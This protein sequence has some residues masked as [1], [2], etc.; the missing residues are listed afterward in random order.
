ML[1]FKVPGRAE[2]ILEGIRR[3]ETQYSP[4]L[5]IHCYSVLWPLGGCLIPVGFLAKESVPVNVQMDFG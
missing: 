4:F 5:V 3:D 2:T 1:R